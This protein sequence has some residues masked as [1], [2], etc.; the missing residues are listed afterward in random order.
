MADAR[1]WFR[2]QKFCARQADGSPGM[3]DGRHAGRDRQHVDHR[4]VHHVAL[5]AQHPAA[6]SATSQNKSG[7][8]NFGRRRLE[9]TSRLSPAEPAYPLPIEITCNARAVSSFRQLA[10]TKSRARQD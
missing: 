3:A 1:Q 6:A 9:E 5:K 10:W 8:A 2:A 7:A 4:L